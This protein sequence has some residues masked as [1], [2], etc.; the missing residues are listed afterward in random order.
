[1]PGVN[2]YVVDRIEIN[3]WKMK[4]RLSNA[5]I[6]KAACCNQR[7]ISRY[8]TGWPIQPNRYRLLK[9]L[10]PDFPD[11]RAPFIALSGSQP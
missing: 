3:L 9:A 2:R 8:C 5:S 4:H 7:T 10:W 6:A 1:M 11:A